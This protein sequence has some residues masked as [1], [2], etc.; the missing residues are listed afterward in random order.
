MTYEQLINELRQGRNFSFA[1]YGDGEFNAMLGSAQ[2]ENCDRHQYFSDMGR[3]LTQIIKSKPG[4]VMGLQPLV[5][6]IR[7]TDVNFIE[8]TSGINWTNADIIHSASKEQRLGELFEVLKTRNI[9]FVANVNLAGMALKFTDFSKSFNHVVINDKDCWLDY[10]DIFKSIR[11]LA[12]EN[13]VILYCASMPTEV[14][15]DEMY[16]L[17]GHKIT[18]IDIGSAF[19]PY[20]GIKSR[21]YHHKLRI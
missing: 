10:P 7:A 5:S 1:R 12:R 18:Q 8:M 16:Q 9:I 11:H 13:D 19:D 21:S 17:Y 6:G 14:L 15:I 4:Y 20:V 3:A 2:R